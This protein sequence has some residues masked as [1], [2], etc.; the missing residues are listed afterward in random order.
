MR[1]IVD[2]MVTPT[3]AL[4]IAPVVARVMIEVGRKILNA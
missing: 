1:G 2:Q 4:E 3:Q